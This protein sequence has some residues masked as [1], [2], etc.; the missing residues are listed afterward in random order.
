[1]ARLNAL[2]YSGAVLAA[3]TAAIFLGSTAHAAQS[4]C[5]AA[6]AAAAGVSAMTCVEGETFTKAP[7]DPTNPLAAPATTTTPS[8]SLP[9]TGADVIPLAVIGGALL[10]GGAGCV[11]VGSRRRHAE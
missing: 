3:G 5:P 9:F 10:A 6:Q 8:S 11:V 7:T 2:H 4:A 1:M